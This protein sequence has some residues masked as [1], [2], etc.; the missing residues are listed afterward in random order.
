[1]GIENKGDQPKKEVVRKNEAVEQENKTA[2]SKRNGHPYAIDTGKLFMQ[3]SEHYEAFDLSFLVGKVQRAF[4]GICLGCT[5][6][7]VSANSEEGKAYLQRQKALYKEEVQRIE[8]EGGFPFPSYFLNL[9]GK[10]VVGL[11]HFEDGGVLGEEKVKEYLEKKEGE[12]D[13]FFSLKLFFTDSFEVNDFLRYH[14]EHSF[15]SNRTLYHDFLRTLGVKYSEYLEKKHQPLI[16][17]FIQHEL[18]NVEAFLIEENKEAAPL[19][20]KGWTLQQ[21]IL[22]FHYSFGALGYSRNAVD[23]SIAASLIRMLIEK[24]S[25]GGN[26]RNTDIYKKFLNPLAKGDAQLQKDLTF[27]RREMEKCDLHKA[28]D[29]LDKDLRDIEREN[30]EKEKK[31]R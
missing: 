3:L 13:L 15:H 6:P 29:L 9:D 14:L 26:V 18:K 17:A 25:K 5:L 20:Q 16:H 8:K 23:V 11:Y 30:K 7:T 12:Y 28:F 19:Q 10:E 2:Q 1:M 24:E 27:I 31:K 22:F 21:K 4:K